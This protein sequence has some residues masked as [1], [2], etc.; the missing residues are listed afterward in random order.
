M[1]DDPTTPAE[2]PRRPRE[3]RRAFH[4]LRALL[5]DPDDTIQAFEIFD[6]VDR[7][8]EERAFRRFAADPVGQRL[9]RTRPSLAAALSD[10]AALAAMVPGSFGRAYLAYLDA[11]RFD[12]LG[13]VTLE[14]KLEAT[15]RARGE[16]RPKLDDA[17]EWFH[18]RG[19]LSH[20]LWHVL[21][22]YGTDDL[23]EATLL[24]FGWAQSRGWAE[25]VLVAGV[26]VR[27]TMLAGPSFP[28]YLFQAWRRGRRS[29]WLPVLPLEELLPE[30]LADVQ[31]A[32]AIPAPLTAHPRGIRRGTWERPRPRAV[33]AT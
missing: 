8:T 24:S 28:R 17:R 11:N 2:A 23:G 22:G 20:D 30:P 14:R 1:R 7:T 16:E 27:G 13:L 19:I 9:L 25:G 6:A 33:T 26:A 31:R 29:S 15:V 5:A 4:A 32:A 3:W 10:R 21:T 18:E 12:P